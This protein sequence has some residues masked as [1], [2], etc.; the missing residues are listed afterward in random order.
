MPR[1]NRHKVS[2]SWLFLA[3]VLCIYGLSG[4]LDPDAASAA[5][6]L[7]YPIMQQVLPILGMVFVLLF[8][9]DVLLTP[10]RVRQYLG[11]ESGLKGWMLAVSA[12][13]LSTGPVYA[14]YAVVAEMQSKGMRTALAAAFLY[15]RA[16]K[17][18]LLPLMIYYFGAGYTSVLCLYLLAFAVINGILVEKLA[19]MRA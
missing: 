19:P 7:F 14:W 16:L 15:S 17:L 6:A 1:Q 5:L 12:G 13:I 2:G 18:P 9:A 3:I 10:A 8:V 11:A 4:L